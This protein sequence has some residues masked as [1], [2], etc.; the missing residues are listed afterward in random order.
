MIAPIMYQTWGTAQVRSCIRM[1]SPPRAWGGIHQ[2]VGRPVARV[3]M[4]HSPDCHLAAPAEV[5]F[6]TQ[7]ADVVCK[8][9]T[10]NK[11]YL[12]G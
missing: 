11:N 1:D 12:E 3:L 5:K 9:P 4:H 6:Q 7:L 8:I 10:V 2:P